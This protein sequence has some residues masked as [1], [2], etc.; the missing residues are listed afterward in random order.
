MRG[1]G[2]TWLSLE[3]GA[4][5]RTLLDPHPLS[6]FLLSSVQERVAVIPGFPTTIEPWGSSKVPS[7]I[8][9]LAE[10]ELPSES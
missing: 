10:I 7:K 4:G 5:Q 2:S 3:K 6:P 1:Q 8:V 9:K